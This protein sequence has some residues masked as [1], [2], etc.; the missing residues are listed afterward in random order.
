[1]REAL[2]DPQTLHNRMILEGGE[3]GG[4]PLRFIASPITLSG[5]STGMRRK[6]PKLGEHTEEVLA[7]ARALA[8]RAAR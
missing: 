7:E 4:R 6:P 2:V 3:A 5:A 1:M 8:A